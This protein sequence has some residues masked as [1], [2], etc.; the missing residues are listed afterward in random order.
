VAI[1]KTKAQQM[2]DA[3]IEAEFE[4]LAGKTI[5]FNGRTVAMENLDA[6]R[7]ARREWEQKLKALNRGSRPGH[8]LARFNY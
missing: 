1:T 7:A 5:T 2:I 6:I 3:C 8:K 4:V